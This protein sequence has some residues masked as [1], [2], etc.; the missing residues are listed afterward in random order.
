MQ[1]SPHPALLLLSLLT[2]LPSACGIGQRPPID[3]SN[4]SITC[5]SEAP[6]ADPD[7]D[8]VLNRLITSPA[9]AP[10]LGDSG[11]KTRNRC[12]QQ[13]EDGDCSTIVSRNS[14]AIQ[15]C[16]EAFASMLC[17]DVQ[18]AVEDIL[19]NCPEGQGGEA[20]VS[21]G[22]KTFAVAIHHTNMSDT[23]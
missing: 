5:T 10:E 17:E 16:G 12:W 3:Y 23:G 2:P 20:T 14:T 7:F 22:D 1:L 19:N 11:V 21:D 13:N 18:H 4:P 6:G 8:D 15:V 9:T